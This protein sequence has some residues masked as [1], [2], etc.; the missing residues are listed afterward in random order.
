MSVAVFVLL[1]LIGLFAIAAI[2]VPV[3]RR[4]GLPLPVLLAALGLA[5]GSASLAYDVNVAGTLKFSDRAFFQRLALDTQSLLYFFLPPLLFEM[6][7]VVNVRRLAQ[8]AVVVVVMAI[9]AVAAVTAIV[10]VSLS[11]ASSL[12]LALCLLLGA[13]VATT[14]PGA[15]ITTFREI[16]APRR[17]LL[18]LE[19]ES[20]LNDAAAI[21]IFTLLIGVIAKA[22][23]PSFSLLAVEFAYGFGVGA[24]TGVGVSA[25]A[26]RIYPML[27]R[28][29]V[30]EVSMTV[31]VAYGSYLAADL[32]FAA[33]GVVAVVFAGLA[34]GSAGFL[35]MGPG[36][37]R[38]VQTIWIQI[39][40]WSNA[41]IMFLAT[42]LVPALLANIGWEVVPLAAIVYVGA[43]LARALVL[44]GLMPLLSAAKFTEPL[45][46][47]Q[48]FLVL[49]GGVRGSVTLLLAISL[50]SIE[51]LGDDRRLVAG[52]AAAYSI[53]A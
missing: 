16:G 23:A 51:A 49:W 20:L 30:A 14:D 8:S 19:G 13:A 46:K 4:L 24:A 2:A 12:G 1:S 44:Y 41:V 21:A 9:L 34:T 47:M 26:S 3:A 50:T 48:S 6:A 40:F 27:A 29:T 52:M 22:V 42:A 36:N 17:L 33:S 5:V 28:S 35:R 15:V 11:L 25:V 39:G 45:S 7:I 38:T 37:W 31:A 43:M 32:V 10:G 18:I 53:L